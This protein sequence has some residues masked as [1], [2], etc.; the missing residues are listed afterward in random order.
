MWGSNDSSQFINNTNNTFDNYSFQCNGPYP[1]TR[2]QL[3]AYFFILVSSLAGNVLI[4]SIFFRDKTLRTS[5]N[6]FIVNMCVSDFMFPIINIPIWI[7]LEYDVDDKWLYVNKTFP[8]LLCKAALIALNVSVLVSV[9]SMTAL[10]ADRY[11]A[12]IFPMKPALFSKKK[13]CVA[14]AAIWLSSIPFLAYYATASLTSKNASDFVSCLNRGWIAETFQFNFWI[15]FTL[16]CWS[17]IALT[18]FYLKLSV[19]LFR[20]KNSLHLASEVVKKRA[21]RN[22]KIITMLI[23]IVILFYVVWIPFFVMMIFYHKR[24]PCVYVWLAYTILPILNPVV[25]PVVYFVFN[26]K[27][28]QG[29]MK[30]LSCL[31]LFTKKNNNH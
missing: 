30:L 22:R 6:Y 20:Q 27:Y 28:C 3:F 23:I 9:F 13:C 21:K 8:T 25:N 10:A 29:F 5:V 1:S 24:L 26:V 16:V 12:I 18:I 2:V 17:G 15:F 14:I 7:T 11:R 19:F 4:I 31:W